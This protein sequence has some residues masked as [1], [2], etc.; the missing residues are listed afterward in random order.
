MRAGPLATATPHTYG[1]D[2][3]DRMTAGSS[4]TNYTLD[5]AGNRIDPSYELTGTGEKLHQYASTPDGDFGYDAA[6]RLSDR[7]T[8]GRSYRYDALGRLKELVNSA[9]GVVPSNTQFLNQSRTESG[10]WV[11]V[12]DY[13]TEDSPGSGRLIWESAPDDLTKFELRFW[14]VD[15]ASPPPPEPY[16]PEHYAQVLLRVME[17]GVGPDEHEWRFLAVTI[18]PD[19]VFLRE[20][21]KDAVDELGGVEIEIP[22]GVWHDLKIEVKDN[23]ITVKLDLDGASEVETIEATTSIPPGG[24]AGLGV[25]ESADFRF[26]DMGSDKP[27][28]GSVALRYHYDAAG[29]VVGRTLDPGGP[30]EASQYFIYDDDRIMLE[31]DGNGAVVAEWVY[32][33]Y[34][35]EIVAMYR[36]TDGQPGLETHYYIQDDLYN[37]VA[38]TDVNGDV[39]E[40]Y[41]Y[42]DFGS[43]R[44]CQPVSLSGPI[45]V[46]RRVAATLANARRSDE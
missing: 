7:T 4:T 45:F 6:G 32:G 46:M 36:D 31:L 26:K 10:S 41:T 20:W 16:G 13:I 8:A 24:D 37:V 19:G 5:V 21:D 9:T 33:V 11:E 15:T 38:L 18:Q 2:E 34:I 22:D 35:D 28:A 25:G 1:Y 42:D 44:G 3:L 39:V 27:V 23:D 29:R 17:F 40:R 12:S 14:R 30:N 43:W